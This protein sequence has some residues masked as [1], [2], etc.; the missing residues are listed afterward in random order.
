[1]PTLR[2]TP[3]WNM[4]A[5][6]LVRLAQTAESLISLAYRSALLGTGAGKLHGTVLL[7]L[8]WYIFQT[9]LNSSIRSQMIITGGWPM[10]SVS[11]LFRYVVA[12]SQ[13]ICIFTAMAPPPVLALGSG[14]TNAAVSSSTHTS[15]QACG[16]VTYVD[17]SNNNDADFNMDD[18]EHTP[19]CRTRLASKW[20][21]ISPGTQGPA[22]KHPWIDDPVSDRYLIM[23]SELI[24]WYRMPV[25]C[26]GWS[27]RHAFLTLA[28]KWHSCVIIAHTIKL[29]ASPW[30][31]GSKLW[32][33]GHNHLR[34][35]GSHPRLPSRQKERGRSKMWQVRTTLLHSYHICLHVPEVVDDPT[36]MMEA[37]QAEV[38]KQISALHSKICS[39]ICSEI[40]MELCAGLAPLSTWLAN[41]HSALSNHNLILQSMCQQSGVSIPSL[42]LRP[43]SAPAVDEHAMSTPSA[44]STISNVSSALSRLQLTTLTINSPTTCTAPSLLIAGPLGLNQDHAP[45]HGLSFLFTFILN[46]ML[47]LPARTYPNP[48]HG[49]W[50][51]HC[52]FNPSLQG[53]VQGSECGEFSGWVA[54]AFLI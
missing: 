49:F 2:S 36:L 30:W 18:N 40:R 53:W 17:E 37:F 43:H 38:A 24:S 19:H 27:S 13:Y 42:G 28:S 16:T 45:I 12:K 21:V 23:Q 47:S 14:S 11:A 31:S 8:G 4:S 51:R 1:M 39:E 52:P 44:S 29:A 26:A 34:L 20:H 3:S 54:H 15:S 35:E 22:S 9:S 25:G 10:I 41:L 46:T 7:R 5:R 48:L 6:L 33:L 32:R 50:V